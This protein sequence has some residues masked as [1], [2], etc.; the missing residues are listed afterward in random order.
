MEFLQGLEREKLA[1][2]Y[3]QYLKEQNRYAEPTIMAS[4]SAA[5]YLLRKKGKKSFWKIIEADNF[6]NCARAALEEI[7]SSEFADNPVGVK[8]DTNYY[9]S[10][11]RRFRRFLVNCDCALV[12]NNKEFSSFAINIPCPCDE[13][14]E[15]Y[16]QRWEKDEHYCSQESA[17]NML[18][19]EK[20]P[21]NKNIKDI[22]LKV[23]TLNDFYSTNIMSTYTMALH[24]YNLNIDERLKE[25]DLTLIDDI[26]KIT[27]NG[28]N[29][30]CYSFATKYCSH[31]KEGIYPIYDRYV[32]KVLKHFRDKDKF[33][34]FSNDELR[35]YE[36]FKQ[37]ICEFKKYYNLKKYTFKQIDHYLWLL[38]K[39]YFP[40]KKK[41][42]NNFDLCG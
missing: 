35:N 5:F 3:E 31:H 30:T 42:D 39:E 19:H 37:V 6:E 15:K 29:K 17:L 12:I 9:L 14:V 22:L 23:S 2:I 1:E 34:S 26:K 38:G 11:L 21:E 4:K 36:Q 40:R 20:C 18:F 25:G 13:E 28:K 33:P 16:L 8:R 10:H 27:I 41:T 7:L 32:D 24:I